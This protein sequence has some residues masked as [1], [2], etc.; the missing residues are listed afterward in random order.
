MEIMQGDNLVTAGS[1]PN[2]MIGA[3]YMII[4]RMIK[5]LLIC[6]CGVFLFPQCYLVFILTCQQWNDDLWKDGNSKIMQRDNL[7]TV[8]S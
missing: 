4:S 6:K 1:L 5:F 7:V 2:N 8:G 3:K